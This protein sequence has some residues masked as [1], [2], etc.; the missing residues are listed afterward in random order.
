[1]A[2][3][4]SN[5]LSTAGSR[6]IQTMPEHREDDEPDD[7]DRAEQPADAV[8]PVLLNHEQS[9]SEST[10]VSGTTYGWNSGVATSRPS[11]APSTVIAG[12]IMPSP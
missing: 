10:T 3:R 1:M 8:R 12:V 2:W 7:H 6:T 4:G 11:I 5:A 9:R